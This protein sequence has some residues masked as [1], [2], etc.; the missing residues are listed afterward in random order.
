[1]YKLLYIV[2]VLVLPFNNAYSQGL[3][4]E[5]NNNNAAQKNLDDAF[6]TI[7]TKATIIKCDSYNY[8]NY[9]AFNQGFVFSR[10]DNAANRKFDRDALVFQLGPLHQSTY[11]KNKNFI[12]FDFN[13]STLSQQYEL[14][15]KSLQL[16]LKLIPTKGEFAPALSMTQCQ[17][18]N[19]GTA[20]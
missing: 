8:N 14:D 12:K 6:N 15:T 13:I 11:V 1:M 17:L 7:T 5:F 2:L 20:F 3:M 16:F 10:S 18:V 4:N 19:K 9:Y